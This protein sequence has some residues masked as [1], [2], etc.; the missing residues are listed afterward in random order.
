[1]KM[2]VQ[3]QGHDDDDEYPDDAT[4]EILSG[5]VL[6]VTSG[7]EIHIYSPAHWQEILIDTR[8]AVERE[9]QMQQL[10]EDLRWQ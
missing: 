9:Q 1:M 3:I 7:C 5:G 8:P 10:D 6:K 2:W 4:Y